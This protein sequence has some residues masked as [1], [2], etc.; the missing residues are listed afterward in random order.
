MVE[1]KASKAP[2]NEQNFQ[3]VG[4]NGRTFQV[5]KGKTVKVPK[6]VAQVLSLLRS[7]GKAPPRNLKTDSRENKTEKL[8][9]GL[10]PSGD[11]GNNGEGG[12]IYEYSPKR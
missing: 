12:K 3:F 5:P 10:G 1:G 2:K 8:R 4:V 9:R 11:F 7:G 6:P